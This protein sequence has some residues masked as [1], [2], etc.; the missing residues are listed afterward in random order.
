MPP[1]Q[2]STFALLALTACGGAPFAA[3]EADHLLPDAGGGSDE[4]T[5]EADPP[6]TS[7][8]ASAEASTEAGAH[9]E[10]GSEAA[11]EASA[12][13]GEAAPTEAGPICTPGAA[14]CVDPMTAETCSSS[15]QWVSETCPYV[16]VG[17][18]C[19]GVCVPGATQQCSEC[20]NQG[21]QTCGD[22]GQWG[23]CSVGC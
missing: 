9:P 17:Q 14:R 6:E 19:G 15:G 7:H 10:G 2:L 16:C 21:E 22:D 23:T 20:G 18:S 13:A 3:I 8:E 1:S 5:I 12:E 4:A 11:T